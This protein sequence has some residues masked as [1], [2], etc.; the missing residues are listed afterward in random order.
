MNHKLV[1]TLAA[2]V[3]FSA[4]A[5][6]AAI[7][8]ES[9]FLGAT[10]QRGGVSI[11]SFQFVGSRFSISQPVDVTAIGGHIGGS[12]AAPSPIFG[13][14]VHLGGPNDLP[15]G[16]P[17]AAGEVIAQVLFTPPFPSADISVPLAASLPAG[18]YAL[19][20][21]GGLFGATGHGFMPQNNAEMPGASYILYG[22]ISP[23]FQQWRDDIFS[24][25]RFLVE[26]VVVSEPPT[27]TLAGLDIKP[28]GDQNPVNLKSRGVLPVA[29][30]SGDDFD[31]TDIDVD[32]ILFGDPVLL[33]GGAIGV[34]PLRSGEKD[35]NGDGLIDLTLKFS[36]RDLV[37]NG[38][39]GGMSIEAILT[40]LTFDG[41]MFEGTDS[42]RLVPPG[43]ANNDLVVDT[44]DYTAWANGFGAKGAKLSDGDFNGDGSV[45]VADYTM[46][47]NHFGTDASAPGGA[48]LAAVPEPSTLTLAA[49]GIVALLAYGWRRRRRA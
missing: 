16:T 36:M 49:L 32:T 35:V 45:D 33:S 6:D 44:A 19:V 37:D 4:T 18:D 24:D 29:F 21:G 41:M 27:I 34:A 5:A 47:A 20:Y 15:T 25:A 7:I 26:G 39:L 13:A 8:H 17:F 38:A 31:A 3:L 48:A 43:D 12:L 14:I 40:G 28:G 1:F 23:G 9:A 2:V 46:L 10:G 42:L 30:L 11:S 22:E